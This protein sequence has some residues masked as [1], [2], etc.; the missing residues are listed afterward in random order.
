M[1]DI[2]SATRLGRSAITSAVRGVP[3]S[4]VPSPNQLPADSPPSVTERP[5]PE[6]T[7]HFSSPSMAPY[8][9]TGCG[10]YRRV[11]IFP[12]SKCHRDD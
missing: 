11:R 7:V 3:R 8:Q 2:P 1:Q 9:C 10:R 5:S 12:E 6:G 4:K